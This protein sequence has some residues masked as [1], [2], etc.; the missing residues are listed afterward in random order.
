MTFSAAFCN[1]ARTRRRGRPPRP[2][3]P[4]FR[5]CGHDP[6]NPAGTATT[7]G[8][9][10]SSSKPAHRPGTEM[11]LADGSAPWRGWARGP[12]RFFLVAPCA[13][14]HT[15]ARDQWPGGLRARLQT[16]T[17][18]A[19]LQVAIRRDTVAR[20]AA[21]RGIGTSAPRGFSRRR[22]GARPLSPTN[23]A[24]AGRRPS[25]A[26]TQRR[27]RKLRL[28]RPISIPRRNSC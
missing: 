25:L 12:A 11:A 18:C 16:S 2:P 1:C 15:P 6:A 22:S 4:P 13:V 26:K 24:I 28:R 3:P 19:V 7:I 10:A 17:S 8:P 21:G 20:A 5:A 27:K 23:A 9:L 14:L